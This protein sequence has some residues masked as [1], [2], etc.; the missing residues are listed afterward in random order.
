MKLLDK[1]GPG[2]NELLRSDRPDGGIIKVLSAVTASHTDAP[3]L[4]SVARVRTPVLA[5]FSGAD[6]QK[7][8]F[9]LGKN[10]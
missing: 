3:M 6:G 4:T 8:R 1:H 9:Y 5:V 7:L 10:L 2:L